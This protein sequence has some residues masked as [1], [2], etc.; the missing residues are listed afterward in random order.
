V[1]YNLDQVVG[2]IRAALGVV[3]YKPT[4]ETGLS[5]PKL[6]ECGHHDACD[7]ADVDCVDLLLC[8][9]G[10]DHLIVATAYGLR[11]QCDELGVRWTSMQ[12]EAAHVGRIAVRTWVAEPYDTMATRTTK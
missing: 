7:E 12:P 4:P 8:P 5:A 1:S 6:R 10:D 11:A 3:P 2:A 9:C